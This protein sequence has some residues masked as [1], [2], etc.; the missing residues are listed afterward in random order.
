MRAEILKQGSRTGATRPKSTP[1]IGVVADDITGAN[2]IGIMFTL[3]GY[4]TCVYPAPLVNGIEDDVEV[5]VLNTNSRLDSPELAYEKVYQATLA[6]VNA[7][8][9]RFFN[10]TCSVFRGNIGAEFDAMLDALGRDFAVVVLGYPKNGRIT[11]NGIHYV[12]GRRLSESEFFHD[13]IHPMTTSNLVD[14]LQSQT[15]RKVDVFPG[16][17]IDQGPAVVEE[18]IHQKKCTCS[19][20]IFDVRSQSDLD[21]I[22][23]AVKDEIVLCGSSALAEFLPAA[24]NIPGSET[25]MPFIPENSNAGV[26]CISGSLTPQTAAQIEYLA[27]AGAAEL[28]LDGTTVCTDTGFAAAVENWVP[29]ISTRLLAG[30]NV[31][32]HAGYQANTIARTRQAGNQAG[33]SDIQ[34][35]RRISTALAEIGIQALQKARQNRLIVAGGETSDAVCNRLGVRGLKIWREIEPGLPS[36]ITLSDPHYLLILK[37]GSFG[38]PA[39]LSDAIHHIKNENFYS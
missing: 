38:S 22:A 19:Y 1:I 24:W 35:S 12:H 4:C 3:S 32:F 26:L 15:R 14:V 30:Q 7:G 27:A 33:L 11:V 39:F 16:S 28:E 17:L 23:K 34:T 5:C 6:L 37:S 36:C 2:D 18:L 10:K 21:T 20:L 13:P 25:I 8:C 9:T 31:V 29:L